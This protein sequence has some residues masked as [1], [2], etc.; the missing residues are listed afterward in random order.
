MPTSMI[1]LGFVTWNEQQPGILKARKNI[2]RGVPLL[3]N[4]CN[5]IIS[6]KTIK[7]KC[8]NCNQSYSPPPKCILIIW[9]QKLVNFIHTMVEKLKFFCKRKTEPI[10]QVI[11]QL[12]KLYGDNNRLLLGKLILLQDNYK[13]P[14][15][16]FT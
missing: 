12:I 5:A 14:I 8:T 11:K 13:I 3:S 1:F 16:F 4:H 9:G 10:E 7:S 2:S 15:F 6:K